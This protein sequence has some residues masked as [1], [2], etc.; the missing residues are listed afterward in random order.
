MTKRSFDIAKII[1]VLDTFK[2]STSQN[3]FEVQ[4]ISGANGGFRIT[5]SEND[6]PD[7][8]KKNLSSIIT[9]LIVELEKNFKG[10]MLGRIFFKE[11]VL[12]YTFV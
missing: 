11:G 5:F 3:F 6:L 2:R 4:E 12:V 8:L 7:N 9:S 10:L 1:P